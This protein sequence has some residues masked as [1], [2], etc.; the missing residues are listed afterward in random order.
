ML[1]R[2]N[3]LARRHLDKRFAALGDAKKFSTPT[4]G[5]I[6]AIREALGMTK[7]QLGARLGVRPQSVSDLE[8]SEA[9]GTIQL[10]TLRKVAEALNCTVVYT[11]APKTPLSEDVTRRARF[12]AE[13]ELARIGHTMRLEAQ[14]VQD[15]DFEDRVERY[16]KESLRDRDLWS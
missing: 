8:R 16:I 5:W 1:S 2:K 13:Q 10:N 9:L 11:L 7:T 4:K 3:Q 14:G 15:E 12:L 6:R